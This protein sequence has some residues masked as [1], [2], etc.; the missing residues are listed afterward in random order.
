MTLLKIANRIEEILVRGDENNYK[1]D[2]FRDQLEMLRLQIEDAIHQKAER[3]GRELLKDNAGNLY[4]P[5]GP[6]RNL[7]AWL[8]SQWPEN[9]EYGPGNSDYEYDKCRDDE[10]L[11][12]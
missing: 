10:D 7:K 9:P 1:S 5:I 4:A 2:W 11:I 8:R 6:S 3:M 12:F